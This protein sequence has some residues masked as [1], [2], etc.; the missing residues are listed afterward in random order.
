[1]AESLVPPTIEQVSAQALR[2]PCSPALLPR[3]AAALQSEDSSAADIEAIIELDPPLAAATLRMANSVYFG[4]GSSGRVGT[5]AGAV[6]R[7]GQREVYRLA[8][9]VLVERWEQLTPLGLTWEPGDFCRHALCTGLAAEV[10]AEKTGQV[11]PAMA[12]TAGL[13]GDIGKLALA[14]ACARHYPAIRA[15]CRAANVSWEQAEKAVLGY[16]HAEVGGMLLRQWRFPDELAAA[17]E[18]QVNPQSAPAAA[19]PLL[20]HLHAAKYLA[21]TLGPGVAE[22]G[23]LFA[24]HGAF[25]VEWG[26]TPEL[27][28]EAMPAVLERATKRLGER[29]SHG[30][31]ELN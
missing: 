3:L 24:L 1:M 17:A 26:F 11:D 31:V 19:L 6:M 4:A 12:Y 5:V 30:P 18:F 10:L 14:H 25:L 16:N 21:T 8:A 22:D 20:A 15:H 2:M 27:F 9:L 29:L 23:F 13:V 7:L 28:D